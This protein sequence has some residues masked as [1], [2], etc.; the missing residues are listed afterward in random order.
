MS[1][2]ASRFRSRRSTCTWRIRDSW[3]VFIA[4]PCQMGSAGFPN[5]VS[6]TDGKEVR[7]E[8]QETHRPLRGDRAVRHHLR[9]AEIRSDAGCRPAPPSS[10]PP[11]P[12]G[13]GSS[14]PAAPAPVPRLVRAAPS[15]ALPAPLLVRRGCRLT[16]SVLVEAALDE[17]G[18]CNANS[19]S[20]PSGR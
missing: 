14:A 19:G 11:W 1:A 6:N 10:P 4:L 5:P 16:A 7:Y 17:V 18:L 12:V 20:E 9:R 2:R 3:F 13:L 15:A 8:Q